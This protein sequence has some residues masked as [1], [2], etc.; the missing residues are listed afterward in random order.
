MF[1]RFNSFDLYISNN[2]SNSRIISAKT[3]VFLKREPYKP[4]E[5]NRIKNGPIV[6]LII[7]KQSILGQ[8]ILILESKKCCSQLHICDFSRMECHFEIKSRRGLLF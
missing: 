8:Q 5:L 1:I 4:I 2:P 7:W 3:Y 6:K